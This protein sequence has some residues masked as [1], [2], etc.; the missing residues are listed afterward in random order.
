MG[1][2]CGISG[3][4]EF[5]RLMLM[6]RV[7]RPSSDASKYNIFAS[8]PFRNRVNLEQVWDKNGTIFCLI[9]INNLCLLAQVNEKDS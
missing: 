1:A 8:Q 4:P 9:V 7:E 2:T 5:N 3:T 6:V